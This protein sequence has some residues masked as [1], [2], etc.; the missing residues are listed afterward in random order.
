MVDVRYRVVVRYRVGGESVRMRI[1]NWVFI[2]HL[3]SLLQVAG[4]K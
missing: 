1:G 3:F 2:N 4:D